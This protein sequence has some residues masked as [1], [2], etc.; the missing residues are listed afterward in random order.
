[1]KSYRLRVTSAAVG[2]GRILVTPCGR[3]FFPTDA[4]GKSSR[5]DG[6]GNPLRLHVTGLPE[7]VETDLPTDGAGRPRWFFRDRKWLKQFLQLHKLAAGDE[8]IITRL[9][10]RDYQIS[11][12]SRE[13]RFIDLFAGIGGMRLG[14]EAAGARC[15]FSCEWDKHAQ[16]TYEANFG[17]K[18]AGDI[19][20]LGVAA[21]R[22]Q[23]H[24]AVA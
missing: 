3:E 15:V 16:R 17:D 9:G 11:P 5:T 24:A 12:V 13:I 20:L 6:V 7:V 2:H 23:F 22:H 1:M 19:R 10:P 18:P 8:V 4:F 14:F 21:S